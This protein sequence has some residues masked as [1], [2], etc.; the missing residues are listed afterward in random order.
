MNNPC[1]AP[2]CTKS[3][4][5]CSCLSCDEPWLYD[6]C[7][8]ECW[9][10][11]DIVDH[12]RAEPDMLSTIAAEQIEYHKEEIRYLWEKN[13]NMETIIQKLIDAFGVKAVNDVMIR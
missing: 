5:T 7:S 6:F 8:R 12:L 1:Q 4:Q 2:G 10:T 11:V 13:E 9:D 3:A